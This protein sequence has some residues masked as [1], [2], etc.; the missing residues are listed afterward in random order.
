MTTTAM[1]F[2]VLV[3]GFLVGGPL[4]CARSARHDGPANRDV[5]T[6]SHQKHVVEQGTACTDC[7]ANVSA[8][9]GLPDTIDAPKMAKCGDC[10]EVK[11]K[12]ELCHPD[13][14]KPG[15]YAT[16]RKPAGRLVFKHRPHV[17]RAAGKCDTCH[18]AVT[19]T[20]R[21]SQIRRPGHN[22]CLACHE[23]KRDYRDLLCDKCHTNLRQFPVQAVAAFNHE[24]NFLG[25]HKGPAKT[26]PG[27]CAQ[28]HMERFCDD[29][30]SRHNELLPSVRFP[31]RVD[32][33]FI[34]RGDWRTR[35]GIEQAASPGSCL[36]CHAQKQCMDCHRVE[37][38]GQFSPNGKTRNSPGARPHPADWMNPVSGNFHGSAARRNI[39]SCAGCHD[40][41]ASSNCVLCHRVGGAGGNPH[42]G[43]KP[44]G[45]ESEKNTN[46]MCRI[47][48]SS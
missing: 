13:P 36:K 34:H 37:G 45:R 10:H 22:E 21:L 26:N 14:K 18:A 5:I 40:R 47:C 38:V 42:P 27:V 16:W 23:H 31:E 39:V 25:E 7:H 12:C 6:F 48:H 2:R 32:R 17:A 3:L 20:V 11:T 35:H 9:Q 15:S 4:G 33:Q 44:R 30:H 29:C 19:K 46:K 43:G 24:G 28:C 1:R 41:G 8:E